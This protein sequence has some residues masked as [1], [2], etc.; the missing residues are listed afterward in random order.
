M[1][2]I[3]T[4][5]SRAVEYTLVGCVAVGLLVGIYHFM[6][7]DVA[8][9]DRVEAIAAGC[10]PVVVAQATRLAKKY[11]DLT[12][13]I[14][15]I[16]VVGDICPDQPMQNTCAVSMTLEVGGQVDK[17]LWDVGAMAGQFLMGSAK[18]GGV[19]INQ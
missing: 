11:P 19:E 9:R 13:S 1:T 17:E 14:D 12:W 15:G 18:L 2:A 4:R 10:R 5:R 6:R 7:R 3:T 8:I 16:N